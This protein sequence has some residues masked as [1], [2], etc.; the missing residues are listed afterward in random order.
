M[1]DDP[2]FKGIWTVVNQQYEQSNE[3]DKK[4]FCSWVDI[5]QHPQYTNEYTIEVDCTPLSGHATARE[6][7]IHYANAD[8]AGAKSRLDL[9]PSFSRVVRCVSDDVKRLLLACEARQ[10]PGFISLD[11]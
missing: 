8:I 6:V 10:T 11:E 2:Y 1:P 7:R 3:T 9:L 5:T 4:P